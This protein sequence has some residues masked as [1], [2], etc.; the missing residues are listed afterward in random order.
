MR[1]SMVSGTGLGNPDPVL[2]DNKGG[3][4]DSEFAKDA[5]KTYFQEY[6]GFDFHITQDSITIGMEPAYQYERLKLVSIHKDKRKSYIQ[7]GK[8][9]GPYGS[10]IAKNTKVYGNYKN[11]SKFVKFVDRWHEV[12]F[13]R[14]K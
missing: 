11:K 3:K 8:A 14:I 10:Q 7:Q 13:G 4:I 1:H 5:F 9:W 12:L 6:D 2:L